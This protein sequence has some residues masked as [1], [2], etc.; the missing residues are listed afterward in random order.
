VILRHFVSE[1]IL[2]MTSTAGV[3]HDIATLLQ[4]QLHLAPCME[5]TGLADYKEGVPIDGHSCPSRKKT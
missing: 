2:K 1:D 4:R 5:E 3:L